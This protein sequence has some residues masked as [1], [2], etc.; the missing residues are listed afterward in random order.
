MIQRTIQPR[1]ER[2]AVM[3]VAVGLHLLLLMFLV[4]L[5]VV[6]AAPQARPGALAALSLFPIATASKPP[7]PA[8]PS[9]LADLKRVVSKPEFSDQADS[10]STTANGGC[11]MLTLVSKSLISDP[12]AINSVIEAPAEIRSVADAVVIWNAGWSNAASAPGAPLGA[13]RAAVEQSLLAAPGQCLDEPIAGPRLIPIPVGEGTMFL[14]FGSGNW[15]WRQ[16][17]AEPPPPALAVP[18]TA[19][20]SRL[21]PIPARLN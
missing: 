12:A 17:L 11:T 4:R 13:A 2:I 9:E 5:G 6:R 14:V 3:A 10:T 15:T 8:L 20:F 7:P 18:Q 19:A 16:L 1:S 21:S